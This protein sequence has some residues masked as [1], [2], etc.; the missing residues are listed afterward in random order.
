MRQTLLG[1]QDQRM[2]LIVTKTN[3]NGD[4]FQMRTNVVTTEEPHTRTGIAANFRGGLPRNDARDEIRTENDF[5]GIEETS[6]F[7]A[8]FLCGP[9]NFQFGGQLR[10]GGRTH[11]LLL[12]LRSGFD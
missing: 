1:A 6:L 5:E 11:S 9:V 3:E 12:G 7:L 10:S 4:D 8:G 2:S